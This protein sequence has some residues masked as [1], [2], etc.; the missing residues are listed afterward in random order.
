ME[1]Y[2]H[3]SIC[4]DGS[5]RAALSLAG[6]LVCKQSDVLQ[7]KSTWA[8]RARSCTE[9]ESIREFPRTADGSGLA[10]TLASLQANKPRSDETALGQSLLLLSRLPP[11]KLR[12]AVAEWL[13]DA[14]TYWL[15]S[16]AASAMV[17]RAVDSALWKYLLA[18]LTER[19]TCL[20][21]TVASLSLKPIISVWCYRIQIFPHPS[22]PALRPTQPPIQW[23]PGFF[24]GGKAVEAWRWPHTPIYRRG[25]GKSWAVPLF[26]LWAFV[27]CSRVNFTFTFTFTPTLQKPPIRPEA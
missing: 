21:V 25:W 6:A 1:P 9:V 10:R 22:K 24:P 23:V 7:F 26:P 15:V 17:N 19:P 20:V 16:F 2:L 14:L 4:L 27:A 12:F 18:N 5:D 8:A 11:L 13:R 3:Y